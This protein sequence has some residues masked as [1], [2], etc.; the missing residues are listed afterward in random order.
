MASDNMKTAFEHAWEKAQR[1][2]ATDDKVK[3][4]QY[5]PEGARLVA[6]FLKEEGFDL[7]QGLAAFPQAVREYVEAG[8]K[9][10]FRSWYRT[11]ADWFALLQEA[12]FQVERLL[13]PPPPLEPP[14][15]ADLTWGDAQAEKASVVPHTLI[16][17][18]RRPAL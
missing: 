3:E 8:L 13:E 15:E 9:E 7:A 1:I 18:A 12:G 16:F 14:T 6:R 2:E 5:G 10:R 4:L 11:V 17:K